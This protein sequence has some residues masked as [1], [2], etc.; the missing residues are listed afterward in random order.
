VSNVRCS[1]CGRYYKKIK[2]ADKCKE[3]HKELT[4]IV[5]KLGKQYDDI[6]SKQ[7]IKSV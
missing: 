1:F 6:L 5:D 4:S 3:C 7:S 2:N